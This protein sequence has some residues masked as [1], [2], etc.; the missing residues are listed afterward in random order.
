[1]QI[2]TH[3][4]VEEK[5]SMR[6]AYDKDNFY[7]A[8]DAFENKAWSPVKADAKKKDGPVWADDSIEIQ[9]V[10]P[11]KEG[12][13][14]YFHLICNT[15]GVIYDAMERDKSFNSN[16]QAKVKKYNDRYVY[17]IKVPVKDMGW[18]IKNG[19][20]WKFFLMRN[21]SNL[22]PPQTTRHSSIDG[23]QAHRPTSYRRAVIGGNVFKNGNFAKLVPKAKAYGKKA[24]KGDK[25]L[26]A[27]GQN[28][29]VELIEGANGNSIKI[30]TGGVLYG[31]IPVTRSQGK[32]IIKGELRASGTGSIAV[33]VRLDANGK[34]EPMK[35]I[36]SF[37]LESEPQNFKFEIPLEANQG[38]LIYFYGNDALLEFVSG[39][40][41]KS[42]N[43]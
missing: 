17:E 18:K 15:N 43:K 21:C 38:V 27:W 12:L 33:K 4:V 23:V 19:D 10:P 20:I 14:R 40:V 25:G 26:E 29:K 24:I 2:R 6:V 34:K 39:I 8:I 30:K 36:A 31:R 5:T 32:Q 22:Q 16:A 3:D 35:E 28:S 42:E 1:M 37:K 7:F 41:V 13:T 11:G 9:I